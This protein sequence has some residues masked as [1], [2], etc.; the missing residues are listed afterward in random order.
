MV[1][2]LK[3][4]K[5]LR[6][7]TISKE[8]FFMA[9]ESKGDNK[10]YQIIMVVITTII[11]PVSVYFI[12][13]SVGGSAN[14]AAAPTST[15]SSSVSGISITATPSGSD[16]LITP[17]PDVP[18]ITPTT[19]FTAAVPTLA[20]PTKAVAEPTQPTTLPEMAVLPGSAAPR[21]ILPAGDASIVDGLAVSVIPQ[22]VQ[23]K[24]EGLSIQIHVRNQSSQKQTFVY[25]VSSIAVADAAGREMEVLYGEKRNAC[26]KKDLSAERK[27]ELAPNQEILLQSIAA[28]KEKNWCTGGGGLF[29]PQYRA[30]SKETTNG[31]VIQFNDFGPFDGFGFQVEK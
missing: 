8:I 13:H 12:T 10:L 4:Q 31:V 6:Q 17:S 29:L 3:F 22:E 23:L 2:S 9:G 30:S 25:R 21:G 11:A 27:I 14:T 26:S 5:Y 7:D 16:I 20:L 18:L 24:D 15:L 28:D 19:T 1:K